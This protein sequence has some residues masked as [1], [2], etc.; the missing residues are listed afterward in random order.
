MGNVRRRTTMDSSMALD[1]ERLIIEYDHL[2]SSPSERGAV[3]RRGA[4]HG[5]GS[6]RVSE[7]DCARVGR[8]ADSGGF[9]DGGVACRCLELGLG[10]S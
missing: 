10:L 2:S 5:R 9:L 7:S 8:R 6:P 4:R 3:L 1:C